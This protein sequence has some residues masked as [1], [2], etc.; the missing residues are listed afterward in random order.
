MFILHAQPAVMKCHLYLLIYMH[1]RITHTTVFILRTFCSCWWR[2][3]L[4]S[5]KLKW[6][7]L[8]FSTEEWHPFFSLN[9]ALLMLLMIPHLFSSA[10]SHLALPSH[11]LSLPALNTIHLCLLTL[12][13]IIFR[14][15]SLLLLHSGSGTK[16]RLYLAC[17]SC[18]SSCPLPTALTEHTR[19]WLI[20][21]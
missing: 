14:L 20:T 17:W 15:H 19:R 5:P 12:A 18:L 6:E 8:I 2:R 13:F 10:S 4:S 9:T 11:H 7:R 16:D 3:C 21:K 1:M